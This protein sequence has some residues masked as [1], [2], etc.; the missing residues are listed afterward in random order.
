MTGWDFIALGAKKLVKLFLG[1]FGKVT[2]GLSQ[3]QR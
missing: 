3:L 2:K 1:A